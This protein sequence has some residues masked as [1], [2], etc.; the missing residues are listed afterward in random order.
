MTNCC[1]ACVLRRGL[2]LL[3]IVVLLAGVACSRRG[4]ETGPPD[5]K[6]RLRVV[7]ST[8]MI[9]DMIR[10]IAGEAV[11]LQVI[12]KPGQD[13]H[14]YKPIPSDPQL[15]T[16][17][18]LVF[19]NGLRLEEYIEKMIRSAVRTQPVV[20]VSEGITP[21]T[22]SGEHAAPDPHI[23]FDVS[24]AGRMAQNIM[25]ALIQY[26]AVNA[27][28][29]RTN[30]AR[31]AAELDEL[32]GWVKRELAAVPP[33]NRKLVTSHDAFSYFGARYGF[34][35]LAVQGIS[36]DAAAQA[37]DVAALIDRVKR[38]GVQALFIETSVNPKMIEQ[39]ANE[40]RVK[41]GGKLYSDS[42]DEPGTSA[43][44]YI[45]MVRENVRTIVEGLK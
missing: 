35:V 44:T 37:R 16:D 21:I 12:L 42:I 28:T 9:G 29:Y 17:A 14:I 38:E 45:G 23:W 26:D 3:G 25:K 36:T 40:A 4:A 30:G 1:G 41:I 5:G 31:Y 15:V 6:G 13:P 18:H 27:E 20:V 2:P 33:A 34:E 8:T 43:G 32:D 7:A 39:V 10:Q 22:S 24:H 19:I 11:D